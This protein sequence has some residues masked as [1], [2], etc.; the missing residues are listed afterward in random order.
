[1]L[2]FEYSF[3][4]AGGT[5]GLLTSQFRPAM[6]FR[7][8]GFAFPVLQFCQQP[9]ASQLAVHELRAGFLNGYAD[10][11][12]NMT[13]SNARCDLVHVLTSRTGS[14]TKCFLQIGFVQCS[15]L[16]HTSAV[17]PAKKLHSLNWSVSNK[18][19]QPAARVLDRISQL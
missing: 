7:C 3:L 8:L 10:V 4:E 16:F 11:S 13:Q 5:F 9:F 19:S 18:D 14:A 2:G 17:R 12:G 15:N 6:F 1:M